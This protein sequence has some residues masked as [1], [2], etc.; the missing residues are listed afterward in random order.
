MKFFNNFSVAKGLFRAADKL[1]WPTDLTTIINL[2]LSDLI[3][4]TG[5]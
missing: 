5:C 4:P 1:F 3:F 2:G